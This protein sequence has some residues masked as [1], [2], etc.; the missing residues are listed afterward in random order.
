MIAAIYQSQQLWG[1][2]GVYQNNAPRKWQTDEVYI[3][4]QIAS[5]LGVALQQAELLKQTQSQKEELATT[6][7]DLQQAQ[8]QLIQNEKMV[9]LGQLVAQKNAETKNI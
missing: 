3:L 9:S 4:S 1:L 2:L 6:L 7:K 8:A 5:Q